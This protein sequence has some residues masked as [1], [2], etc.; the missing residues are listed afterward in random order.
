MARSRHTILGWT[1]SAAYLEIESRGGSGLQSEREVRPSHLRAS[2]GHF[3][4]WILLFTCLFVRTTPPQRV[5]VGKTPQ[6]RQTC[7]VRP[8][9][10]RSDNFSSRAPS[11]FMAEHA[12]CVAVL[13]Q[14]SWVYRIFGNGNQIAY[15]WS[16]RSPWNPLSFS[17][18]L[19]RGVNVLGRGADV[20][21]G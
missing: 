2:S 3:S 16:P 5:V 1:K 19:R 21:W 12:H 7:P 10:I 17:H 20:F 6:Q 15:Y 14:G 8:P 13:L 9:R 4:F 18:L 11:D